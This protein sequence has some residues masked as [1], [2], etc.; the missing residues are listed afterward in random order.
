MVKIEQYE[1]PLDFF[2][3]HSDKVKEAGS[4]FIPHVVEPSFGVE[5]LVYA[6][7]EYGLQM[8]ED[9]L[10]LSLPFRLAPVQVSVLPLV[11]VTSFKRERRPSSRC[12][13]VMDS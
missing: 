2:D 5:R 4:R 3:V 9:R 1:V 6:A 12:C 7:L 13:C 10:I 8:K 11:T